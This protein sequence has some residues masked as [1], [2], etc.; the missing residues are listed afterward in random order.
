MRQIWKMRTYL[1][2]VQKGRR[3]RVGGMVQGGWWEGAGSDDTL[4][5]PLHGT[6][7]TSLPG[8]ANRIPWAHMNS[9]ERSCRRQERRKLARIRRR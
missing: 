4:S 8:N 5:A 1:S 9:L 3:G 7:T 6:S 2:Q